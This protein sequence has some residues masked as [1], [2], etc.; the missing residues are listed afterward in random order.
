MASQDRHIRGPTDLLAIDISNE[1]DQLPVICATS[2]VESPSGGGLFSGHIAD[3][4]V[5][6]PSWMGT[7]P[8]SVDEW[9]SL[10]AWNMRKV[11]FDLR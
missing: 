9:G 7:K 1:G 3:S 6:A 2:L 4:L 8:E 11:P 5:R 10:S